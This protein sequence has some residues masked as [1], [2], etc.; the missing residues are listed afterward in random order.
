MCRRHAKADWPSLFSCPKARGQHTISPSIL[1]ALK[2]SGLTHVPYTSDLELLL[3][4]RQKYRLGDTEWKLKDDQNTL[5]HIYS[6]CRVKEPLLPSK[7]TFST[8][9]LKD[10]GPV[11]A[12]QGVQDARGCPGA[13]NFHQPEFY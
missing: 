12:L 2:C 8:S 1:S 13:F 5:P 10:G 9:V 3:Y 7:Y 4:S 11:R 6:T